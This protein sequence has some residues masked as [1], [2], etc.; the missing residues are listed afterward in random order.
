MIDDEERRLFLERLEKLVSD[1]L[2][3]ENLTVSFLAE[4][5]C[6]SQSK[7]FRWVKEAAGVGC[8]EY[9]RNIRLAKAAECLT[10]G[11]GGG[12][13]VAIGNVAFSCGFASLSS[14]SKAFRKRYGM[15]ATEYMKIQQLIT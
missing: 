10:N 12:L 4:K 3:M 9:I 2:A 7:L 1:N 11:R 8:N 15:S 13:T 6:M 5:M 14:F